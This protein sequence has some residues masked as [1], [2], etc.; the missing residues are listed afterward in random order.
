M[1]TVPGELNPKARSPAD[2]ERIGMDYPLVLSIVSECVGRGFVEYGIA[3]NCPPHTPIALGSGHRGVTEDAFWKL[4]DDSH[5][6]PLMTWAYQSDNKVTQRRKIHDP[7]R[8]RRCQVLSSV[9]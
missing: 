4:T 2:F 9:R 1:P 8:A 3:V 7:A 5:S 6:I